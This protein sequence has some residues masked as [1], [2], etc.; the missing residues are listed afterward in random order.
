MGKFDYMIEVCSEK[1]KEL[2]QE[3]TIVYEKQISNEDQKEWVSQ[4]WKKIDEL[5]LIIKILKPI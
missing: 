1:I 3:M 2:H 5:Q 4:I